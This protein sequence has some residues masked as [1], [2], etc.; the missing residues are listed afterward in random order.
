MPPSKGKLRFENAED[1]KKILDDIVKTLS[2]V[3]WYIDCSKIHVVRSYNS[4]SIAIARIH[5]LPRIWLYT[6]KI[7]P[8][9]VIEV[10]SERFDRL[11]EEDKI[12]I[13]IHELLHIPKNF[14]GSLRPHKRFITSDKI[15]KLS[16]LYYSRKKK[17]LQSTD[18]ARL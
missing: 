12:H 8:Q 3:F 6:L 1:V 18:S 7:K 13:L 10:I 11:G 14:S 16:K 2:D 9:Y 15:R 4:K 5:G 17:S